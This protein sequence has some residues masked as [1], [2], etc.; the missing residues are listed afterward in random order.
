MRARTKIVITLALLSGGIVMASVADDFKDASGRSGCD[1]IPYSS[2]RGSCSS[3]GPEVETWCK[4]KKWNCDDLDPS[5][6]QRNIDNVNGKISDLQKEKSSM[7]SERNSSSDESKRKDLENKIA[8]KKKQIE[9]LQAKVDGWKKQIDTEKGWARDRQDIGERCVK[10]RVNV[11]KIF[12]GVKSR[13][14]NESD[15]EAKQYVSKLG[16]KYIAEEKGH[17]EAIDVTNRGIDKCK[18]LR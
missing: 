11:Q 12:A 17:Q 9:D 14:Q 4:T 15:P 10:E 5:G 18:G 7:E 6:I 8:D 1:S 13:V 3:G 2:D 16:D